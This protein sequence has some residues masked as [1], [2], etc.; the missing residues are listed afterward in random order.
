MRRAE[1]PLDHLHRFLDGGGFARRQKNV[2]M[3]GHE[4]KGVQPVKSAVST[5]QELFEE[6]LGDF[7]FAKQRASL[8]RVSGDKVDPSL[9]DSPDDSGQLCNL[10]GLKALREQPLIIVAKATTHKEYRQ[11]RCETAL[12]FS[13]ARRD[14]SLSQSRDLEQFHK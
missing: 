1:P 5:V 14:H 12:V 6:D 11:F 8:P 7:G 3:V 4:H 13:T 2:Q 10:Q 9:V